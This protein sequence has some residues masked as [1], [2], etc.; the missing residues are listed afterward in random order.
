MKLRTIILASVASLALGAPAFASDATGWYLGVAGGWDHIDNLDIKSVTGGITTSNRVDTG[1]SFLVTGAVGYRFRN[2]LR[3]ELET[4]Y[5]PHNLRDETIGGTLY[6]GHD[7]IG[8]ALANFIYDFP[9]SNR[10]DFSL[11]GGAGA[12][13]SALSIENATSTFAAGHRVGFMWQGIAGFAYSLT[14]QLDLTFDYR[15]RQLLDHTDLDTSLAATTVHLNNTNEQAAM[16]GLRWY[17]EP[18]MEAQPPVPPPPPAPPPPPPPAPPPVKTFI[19][20]F[21]F[22]KSDLTAEA[23]SVVQQAVKTAKETGAVRILV[24]GHTDT[25][26]SDSYNQGLSVRRAD[27]VKGEMV[28][29]GMDGSTISIEGKSFHDPLVPTGPGVREP[30]NRR[31]VIDLNG[32]S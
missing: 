14:P 16:M 18:T 27:T 31:A 26:G 6:G 24:T 8:S 2:H 3:F 4:G 32:G 10:L 30:Q 28:R 11:G 22:N 19:V 5:T 1:D 21:D 17:L 15:Y 20:F 7:H 13:S 25:V 29:E 12:G 9:L 23:Q